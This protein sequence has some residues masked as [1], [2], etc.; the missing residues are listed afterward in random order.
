MREMLCTFVFLGSIGF[1]VYILAIY[2]LFLTFLAHRRNRPVQKDTKLR[3]VSIIV[4]V[5][6]GE[7]FIAEKLRSILDLNYPRQLLQI[8]VVSDGSED[9]TDEIVAGFAG[10]GVSLVRVPRGGKP[11]ALNA[12]IARA[13]NELLIL[14]DVRQRLDPDSVRNLV[15]CFGD[16]TVGAASGRLTIGAGIK[17]EECDTGLYWKYEVFIRKQLSRL[18]STFGASGHFYAVRRELAVNIPP[19]TLLDD[20]YLPM[21]AFFKGFRIVL[22][23]TAVT[24]DYPT[25][26][27][28]EFRRKVRTQAGLYQIVRFYPELLSSTNRMRAHFLCAK[29]GRL[30]MPFFLILIFL[31]SFGLPR[32]FNQLAIVLQ[33]AF[34]A[35]AAVDPWIPETFPV[36]GKTSMIRTFV[37]L[38]AAAL[39]G[40]SIFFVTPRALWKETKVSVLQ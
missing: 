2:P 37:V 28:S 31:S 11:A 16:P 8:I 35:T 36:K 12:G 19:D 22:D 27:K 32:P 21:A 20:V 10:E 33:L 34:Y 25:S 9:R 38:M 23:E 6:N 18:D 4:A 1:L 39:M 7:R 30:V 5:W 15:G 3:S 13:T 24:F 40:L 29:F 14:T 26:L 17:K